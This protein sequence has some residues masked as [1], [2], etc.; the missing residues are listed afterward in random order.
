MR[1]A[2]IADRIIVVEGPARGDGIQA[3]KAGLLELADLIIVNKSDLPGADK[4]VNDLTMSLS[5]SN[6]APEIIKVSALL[7]DGLDQLPAM[8]FALES[9]V[10]SQRARNR[11]RL[12]MSHEHSLT[13][14]P[15]FE[16]VLD[17]MSQEGLSLAQA[18]EELS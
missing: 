9:R 11:Q 14:N 13:S 7:G 1:C 8:I 5:L 6:D 18:L 15:N 16:A 17:R 3:E 12:L 10:S 2:A 4:V